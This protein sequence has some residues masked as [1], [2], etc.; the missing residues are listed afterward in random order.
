[1]VASR[2]WVIK[3]A[4]GL[5]GQ[6]PFGRSTQMSWPRAA[7]WNMGRTQPWDIP[8]QEVKAPPVRG[9]PHLK[10]AEVGWVCQAPKRRCVLG[11]SSV[12]FEHRRVIEAW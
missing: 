5:S 6:H 2:V 4:L 8:E 3:P 7:P 9:Q 10:V 11:R 1:M 12:E